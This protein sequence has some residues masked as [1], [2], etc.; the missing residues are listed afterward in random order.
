VVKLKFWNVLVP[1]GDPVAKNR[2]DS[3]RDIAA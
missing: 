3:S 1:A 2:A